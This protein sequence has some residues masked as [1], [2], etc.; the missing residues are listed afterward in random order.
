[1]RLTDGCSHRSKNSSNNFV[2][3]SSAAT[4]PATAATTAE[5]DTI[6][7][8]AIVDR[9]GHWLMAACV[10]TLL[11]TSF[12]PILGIQFAWVTIH[13]ATGLVLCVAVVLH[14][15]RSLIWKSVRSMWVGAAD[16]R[17]VWSVASYNLRRSAA[18]PNKP[19]KYSPTLSVS[20]VGGTDA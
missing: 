17:D 12:L 16:L 10:L 9:I 13:W 7:R 4:A 11:A 3:H 14:T 15:V 18:L 5:N 20:G 2:S 8:H 6:V 19:G 1:M